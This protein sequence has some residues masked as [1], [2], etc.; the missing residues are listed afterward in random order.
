MSN[1]PIP[2]LSPTEVARELL[3]RVRAVQEIT[4]TKTL[5]PTKQSRKL[6]HAASLPDDFLEAVAVAIDAYEKLALISDVTAAEIREL[7][8]YSRANRPVVDELRLAATSLLQDILTRRAH[9][10]Q[11]ALKVYQIVQGLNRPNDKAMLVPHITAMRRALGKAKRKAAPP[12]QPVP[13]APVT[14]VTK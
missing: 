6:I 7:I 4:G 8:A 13:P 2:N 10:G 1:E 12:E 14:P 5:L 9:V 11:Q 3:Q